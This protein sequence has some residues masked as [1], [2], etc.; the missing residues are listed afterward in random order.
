M[1]YL[2]HASQEYVDEKVQTETDA[3]TLAINTA[4]S[5]LQALIQSET[6]RA[7]GQE[8]ILQQAI[9]NI[10]TFE[11][12]LADTLPTPSELCAKKIYFVP[13]ANPKATNTK[14]EYI[15]VQQSGTWK[16]E[17]IGSTAI[18]LEFDLQPTDGSSKL[19]RS[20]GIHTWGKPALDH[21]QETG[22]PHGTTA[23]E[24]GAVGDAA[25]VAAFPNYVPAEYEAGNVVKKDTKI[26]RCNE[27]I[28]RNEDETDEE[29]ETRTGIGTSY[30][31]ETTVAAVIGKAVFRMS[32]IGNL[33]SN[34]TDD[35]LTDAMLKVWKLVGGTTEDNE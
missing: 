6:S 25:T 1:A 14:D 8:A 29:L 18:I 33:S 3:R 15:C 13:S 24:V 22:N 32:G 7:S 23:A 31:S 28:V 27:A 10:Q 19:V 30:W 16:W 9:N 34:P 11:V 4:K 35:E 26:Y 21:A 12:V 2:H 20:G 17:Q 5:Q